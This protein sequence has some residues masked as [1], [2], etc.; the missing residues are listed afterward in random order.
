METLLLGIEVFPISFALTIAATGVALPRLQKAHAGQRILEIGPAWHK[1]KEGTPTMG[2]IAPLI[3]TLLCTSAFAAYLSRSLGNHMV[4][5]LLT[6]LFATGNGCI[7]LVDDLTKIRHARNLGLTPWQKL[8]LQATV[9][10]GYL[11]LLRIHGIVDSAVRIPFTTFEWQMGVLWYPFFFLV[12]LWFVNCANL[13]DGVDGLASSVNG[14]IGVFYFWI[15]C[16]EGNL[17]LALFSSSLS[18][19]ALGLL[20][21]NRQP[22]R[23][24]MGDTGSLF[25]GALVVGCAMIS[26]SPLSLFFLAFVFL[27]EGVS[28]VLQVLYFKI[29]HGKRLFKMAPLHHHLEKCGMSEWGITLSAAFLTVLFGFIGYWSYFH[30]T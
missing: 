9:A 8:F 18:G 6:F 23:I 21:Y 13:T 24:Y 5:W 1:S 25:F 7:G 14:W 20:C 10:I 19:G 27:A 4:P 15:A 28:V 11:L 30:A 12:I 3:A 16:R 17:S 22:A 26:S 2:G 29:T